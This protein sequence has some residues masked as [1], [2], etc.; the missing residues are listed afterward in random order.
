M[1]ARR[2]FDVPIAHSSRPCK[3]R[4]QRPDR[5]MPRSQLVSG[6]GR[7]RRTSAGSICNQAVQAAAPD[8]EEQRVGRFEAIGSA[9]SS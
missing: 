7:A 4:S 9:S 1:G 8:G 3:R 6:G 5:G 2:C